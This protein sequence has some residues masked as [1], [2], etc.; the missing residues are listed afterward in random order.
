MFIHI[1][2]CRCHS[3][4]KAAHSKTGIKFKW[5]T[6]EW[7][8]QLKQ[9]VFVVTW[10]T[11]SSAS[12]TKWLTIPPTT[13]LPPNGKSPFYLDKQMLYFYSKNWCLGFHF[14]VFLI[15][16]KYNFQFYPIHQYRK[17]YN[18]HR[19]KSIYKNVFYH[20]KFVESLSKAL[21]WKWSQQYLQV[22]KTRA[23]FNKSFPD[24]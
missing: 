20:L 3:F 24:C 2:V 8:F 1:N 12:P 13:V 10:C 4:V 14:S 21:Q 5:H 22:R 19:F 16:H 17:I 23:I 15:S 18:Y 7:H 11:A 9:N 6:Q